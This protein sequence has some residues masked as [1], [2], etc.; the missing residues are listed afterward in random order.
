MLLKKIGSWRTFLK[1]QKTINVK[2]MFKTR[3]KKN[4][5]SLNWVFKNICLRKRLLDIFKILI[6]VRIL[7]QKD[8]C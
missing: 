8:L 5:S 7:L 3:L 2:W 4:S 6:K 1:E